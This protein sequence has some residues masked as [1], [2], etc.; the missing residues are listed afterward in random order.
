MLHAVGSVTV[1]WALLDQAITRFASNFWLGEHSQKLMPREFIR[2]AKYLRS[3]GEAI[4][5]NKL[6]E[7]DEYR[8]F[9]WFMK[10]ITD[11]HGLRDAIA[12]GIPGTA[13]QG[14]RRFRALLIH[15]PSRPHEIKPFSAKML[16]KLAADIESLFDEL[17]DVVFAVSVAHFATLPRPPG[18]LPP[19]VLALYSSESRSPKLPRL[20]LPPPTFSA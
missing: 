12:H 15:P 6:N 7:P 17:S 16:N 18:K 3:M 5:I 13:T 19:E 1:W 4:Y 8:Q 10:R 9:C 11:A 14:K 20:S 2:R